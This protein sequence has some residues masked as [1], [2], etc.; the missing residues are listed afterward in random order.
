MERL[1]DHKETKV[2][3]TQVEAGQVWPGAWPRT[4]GQ[5]PSLAAARAAVGRLS[6]SSR[7]PGWRSD[8]L[9]PSALPP[10]GVWRACGP[11]ARTSAVVGKNIPLIGRNVSL[12]R[13]DGSDTA[14]WNTHP[15]MGRA[16]GRESWGRM[17]SHGG[18]KPLAFRL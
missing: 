9:I 8:G 13:G 3:E 1:K 2:D 7:V 18:R 17:G 10:A 14:S 15:C 6:C 16:R 4:R 11:W 12:G 5:F